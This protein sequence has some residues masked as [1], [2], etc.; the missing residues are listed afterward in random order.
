MRA[1]EIDAASTFDGAAGAEDASAEMLWP[2]RGTAGKS[3]PTNPS[4]LN[5]ACCP[6][7]VGITS[8][9]ILSLTTLAGQVFSHLQQTDSECRLWC[10]FSVLCLPQWAQRPHQQL[11][12]SA[13]WL[14]GAGPRAVL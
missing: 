8:F 6:A 12:F 4:T 14:I 5:C 10:L 11:V 13:A 9:N 1:L 2:K 7:P 3:E